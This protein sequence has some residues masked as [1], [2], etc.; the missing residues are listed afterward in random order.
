MTDVMRD[1][2]MYAQSLSTLPKVI[3]S[4]VVI[5]VAFLVL[6]LLWTGGMT[7]K[8]A[9]GEK[10]SNGKAPVL[11]S[12]ISWDDHL[13]HSYSGVGGGL[14]TSAFQIGAKNNLGYELRLERAYAISGQGA[15]EKE[16][17]IAAGSDWVS[18]DRVLPLGDQQSFVVRILFDSEPARIVFDNW[19]TF[20]I[21]LIYNDG[22]KSRKNVTEDMVRS[23]YE[24]FKPS[25]I[26]PQVHSK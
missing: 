8:K 19:R 3:I 26:G 18:A 20:Q 10:I 16:L 1:A 23:V 17:T 2:F 13:G 5:L 6:L 4:I 15:G 11:D 9:D 7:T 24:G 12:A 25:P 21:T 22:L 14:Q